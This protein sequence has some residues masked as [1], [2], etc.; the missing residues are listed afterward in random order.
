MSDSLQ[1]HGLQHARLFCP[2]LSPEVGSNSC[3]IESV[4]LSNHFILCCPFFY[5][6]FPAS[7]SFLR[8]SSLHQVDFK[9]SFSLSSFTLIKSLFSFSSL[10][11]IRVVS[12]THL[13]LLMY[14]SRQSWFPACDP[15]SLAFC[16][17][18]SAYMLNRQADNIQ[19]CSNYFFWIGKMKLNHI[20]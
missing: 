6:L 10:S 14:F 20:L 3:P 11:V 16:L 1:P 15:S 2:S 9:L 19:S 7:G 4:M 12:S 18:C 5:L 17:M 13:N 8:V